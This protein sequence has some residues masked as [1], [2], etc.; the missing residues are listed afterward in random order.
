M[1]IKPDEEIGVALRP[2]NRDIGGMSG[3]PGKP[4]PLPCSFP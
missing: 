4:K 1:I 2:P 3:G